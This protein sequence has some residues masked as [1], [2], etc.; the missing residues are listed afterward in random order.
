MIRVARL[1]PVVTAL[2][3]SLPPALAAQAATPAATPAADPVKDA[4]PEALLPAGVAGA[5]LAARQAS[6]DNDYSATARYTGELLALKVDQPGVMEAAIQSYVVLGDFDAA[7]R[8]AQQ[9]QTLGIRSQVAQLVIMAD[10]LGKAQYE[11]VL[12]E[13]A[14]GHGVGKLV[15]GLIEGWADL[16]AG[17]MSEATQAFDALTKDPGMEAFGLYHKALALASVGDFEG[18][19][20][21][22]GDKQTGLQMTRRSVIAEAEVLSQLERK[23]DAL[24]LLDTHFPPGRDPGV[25][26]MRD[27]LKAGETLPFTVVRSPRDGLAEVFFTVASALQG[28][29][30]ND[31]IILFS[32]IALHLRPH[33][34]GAALLAADMLDKEQQYDLALKTYASIPQDD[35]LHYVAEMGR[36]DTLFA[37]GQKAEA[38]DALARLAKAY[39]KVIEV[40]VAYGDVLRRQKM[41]GPAIQAYDAAALLVGPEPQPQQWSV[42]YM[43]GV[44][45]ERAGNWAKAEPDLRE[46][47]RLNPDQPDVLNYLGYGLVER[48]EKLDEAL[49]MINKAVKERPNDGYIRDSLGWAYYTLGEYAK[50]LPVMEKASELEPVDAIVTD[51][52]GDVYWMNGRKLEAQFQWRRALSYGPDAEE[53]ARIKLKLEKG[54]D[55][56]LKQEGRAPAEPAKASNP[57]AKAPTTNGG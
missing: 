10:Q 36:A 8:V 33:L 38:T 53:A 14:Q 32:E 49:T 42:F 45:E 29:A 16:G 37:Q 19:E 23:A 56:V 40:Q 39:P 35:P 1:L 26:A 24:K 50:A 27:R 4:A 48:R 55:E 41:W 21:I 43:R 51:H 5:Y 52:L 6:R 34:T 54:L 2:L 30:S 13:L 12:T 15:D 20:K 22:L 17:K 46:A 57:P 44:A 3:L 18:A 31:Y 28:Q 47:L 7:A 9:M 25:D 11:A